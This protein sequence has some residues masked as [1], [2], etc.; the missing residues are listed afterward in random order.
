M[1]AISQPSA[2]DVLKTYDD[3]KF[4]L[5]SPSSYRFTMLIAR[6][7]GKE[8]RRQEEGQGH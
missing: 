7:Q 1:K 8:R 4:N 5:R 6:D 3:M 2:S